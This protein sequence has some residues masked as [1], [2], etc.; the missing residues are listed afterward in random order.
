[1]APHYQ[2]LSWILRTF[3]K[4]KN[5]II[6]SFRRGLPLVY[7]IMKS[8]QKLPYNAVL[9]HF[10][11]R[12]MY[13]SNTYE[14]IPHTAEEWTKAFE[15]FVNT[16]IKKGCL[17][18]ESETAFNYCIREWPHYCVLCFQVQ[19][20]DIVNTCHTLLYCEELDCTC[21][22][23]TKRGYAIQ[24]MAICFDC[25]S[26]CG[27]GWFVCST[28]TTLNAIYCSRHQRSYNYKSRVPLDKVVK[29]VWEA[30][31]ENVDANLKATQQRISL[32]MEGL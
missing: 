27:S 5:K 15:R 32:L 21:T 3:L 18:Y 22:N 24:S 30:K 29:S 28:D 13:I 12:F 20:C 4:K 6:I 9:R 26:N 16:R 14:T 17:C 25:A 7:V 23:P 2:W 11:N 8:S 19:G 1:M 31:K 10:K